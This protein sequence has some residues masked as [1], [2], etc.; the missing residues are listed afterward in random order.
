M[1]HERI[2]KWVNMV[3]LGAAMCCVA[4][5]GALLFFRQAPAEETEPPEASTDASMPSET[6]PVISTT[7]PTI[8]ETTAATQ[9]LKTSEPV[10]I[11]TSIRDS[12]AYQK[13]LSLENADQFDPEVLEAFAWWIESEEGFLETYPEKWELEELTNGTIDLTCYTPLTE[14][15]KRTFCSLRYNGQS[16]SFNTSLERQYTSVPR[17]EVAAA[18]YGAEDPVGVSDELKEAFVDFILD[19]DWFAWSTFSP[20]RKT[21]WYF[22]KEPLASSD[23]E[24]EYIHLYVKVW[25]SGTDYH[26]CSLWYDGTEVRDGVTS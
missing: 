16:V 17:E 15:Y 6:V 2:I 13:L 26:L 5:L 7:E 1:E 21:E 9:P 19:S 23:D 14:D 20:D 25:V 4:A 12:E 3:A 18:V 8:A 10:Q 24:T 11:E 22:A